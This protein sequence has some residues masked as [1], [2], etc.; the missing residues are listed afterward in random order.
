MATKKKPAAKSDFSPGDEVYIRATVVGR[1]ADGNLTVSLGSTEFEE[2]H[3]VTLNQS[4]EENA[5][6]KA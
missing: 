3:I 2:G 5:V 1:V 4:E 6:E